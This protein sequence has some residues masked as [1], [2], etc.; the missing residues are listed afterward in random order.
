MQPK[1][2]ILIPVYKTEK[3][4]TKCIQSILGQT[5]NDLE[6]VIVDDASPDSSM[7]IVEHLISTETKHYD[8]KIIHNEKNQGIA[9]V[10]NK[11]LEYATGDY[12]FFVDSDDYLETNAVESLVKIIET[13][14][15]DIVRSSYFEVKDNN[16]RII[17]QKSWNNKIHLLKQH[18]SAWNSIEAMWQLFIRRSLIEEHHLRFPSGINAAEDHLMIIKLY[19]YAHSIIDSEKPI[20]Y[21]RID[22]EQSATHINTQE[23]NSSMYK[24]MDNAISFLKEKGVYDVYREELLTRTFLTKQ[25]FLLNKRNRNI[26][27]Y[28]NTHPECNSFY[29][30]IKYSPSQIIL[31]KLAE[32]K[33]RCLLKILNYII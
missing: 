30:K 6:I 29:K 22:N 7:D 14:G 19:Y 5:Y 13:T 2:S 17:T 27:L 21:Y 3:Y 9:S 18:I 26:D 32:Y 20:Y 4:I 24:A 16:L 25:N 11:L 8:I 15:C 1:V 31:F 12:I 33:F 28:L 10:R 23:F